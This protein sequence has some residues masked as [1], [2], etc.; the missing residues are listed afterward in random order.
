MWYTGE[1]EVPSTSMQLINCLRI[2][3]GEL[4]FS[5]KSSS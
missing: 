3:N 5:I 4:V 2:L 1:E